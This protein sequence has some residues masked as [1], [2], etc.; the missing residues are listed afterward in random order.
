MST[1][2]SRESD[3]GLYPSSKR[4]SSSNLFDLGNLKETS[5]IQLPK[6]QKPKKLRSN[7]ALSS[8]MIKKHV[9]AD[10]VVKKKNDDNIR[11][12]FPTHDYEELLKHA[13]E[14]NSS[15]QTKQLKA[16]KPS[17]SIANSGPPVVSKPTS[18]NQPVCTSSP[19][20]VDQ[21]NNADEV[22][23]PPLHAP[24]DN[25]KISKK[26]PKI[27]SGKR[28]IDL[29]KLSS[30]S[31][32]SPPP[33]VLR[34]ASD[35]LSDDNRSVPDKPSCSSPDP[36]PDP[37][38]PVFVSPPETESQDATL[39]APEKTCVICP[40]C[41]KSMSSDFALAC[42]M[43]KRHKVRSKKVFIPGQSLESAHDSSSSNCSSKSTKE[44]KNVRGPPEGLE[45][46][47]DPAT[48]RSARNNPNASD[49]SSSSD[50]DLD[51]A[52]AFVY[53]AD[54][55]AQTCSDRSRFE[56]SIDDG[57]ADLPTASLI[58][59]TSPISHLQ[60]NKKEDDFDQDALTK[61]DE[62]DVALVPESS[63]P[64]RHPA[65]KALQPIESLEKI[66]ENVKSIESTQSNYVASE[67]SRNQAT[68][69]RCYSV[70][71][72]VIRN[73]RYACPVDDCQL[74][75][76]HYRNLKTHCFKKHWKEYQQIWPRFRRKKASTKSRLSYKKPLKIKTNLKNCKLSSPVSEGFEPVDQT[77]ISFD[78]QTD[79]NVA[80]D[81]NV[82]TR[83]PCAYTEPNQDS[84][85][86]IAK[87]AFS[88]Q[89]RSRRNVENDVTREPLSLATPPITNNA[90]DES[91]SKTRLVQ[92][93]ANDATENHSS[94]QTRP[95]EISDGN[96]DEAILT[97]EVSS[98]GSS[99]AIAHQK[100]EHRDQIGPSSSSAIQKSFFVTTYKNQK[101]CCPVENCTHN[102]KN[103]RHLKR[104]CKEKHSQF[105][106]DF[107]ILF[108]KT[109]EPI[110]W[111]KPQTPVKQV[112]KYFCPARDCFCVYSDFAVLQNHYTANHFKLKKK[113]PIKSKCARLVELSE[114]ENSD[115][116]ST[117]MT[118]TSKGVQAVGIEQLKKSSVPFIAKLRKGKH[119]YPI[120][121]CS[122]NYRRL[123]DREHSGKDKSVLSE[124]D[125]L[126]RD[127]DGATKD[128]AF[129]EAECRGDLISFGFV[130]L[131][132]FT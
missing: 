45:A 53:S 9:I 52:P 84:T 101:Y 91:S 51:D 40:I 79:Q 76:K 123:E 126:F 130:F 129:D 41:S 43:R 18:I 122:V 67:C 49:F 24:D 128:R 102:Y 81:N 29:R 44:S 47:S 121:G 5:S 35:S 57:R 94:A 62:D 65:D 59:S 22:T 46:C 32:Y 83:S 56:M 16:N 75:Y 10:V 74:S 112:I 69:E 107:A 98:A 87:P 80:A 7:R 55:S 23:F 48:F 27:V 1:L 127:D 71:E 28:R 14:L 13:E 100:K 19:D 110:H 26:A 97:N 96:I 66:S 30:L 108:M 114:T 77:D 42:H 78:A 50:D 6:K 68:S 4:S 36:D 88:L 38:E 25:D 86:D 105:Y 33:S 125:Q 106:L 131:R 8:S 120:Q 54:V 124:Q 92:V 113:K 93:S 99:S 111:C 12:L 11:Q 117:H 63:S 39:A 37:P 17:S 115:S 104:H 119:R 2:Q 3:E 85:N 70:A 90:N 61:A 21:S 34:N 132:C 109:S 116:P 31:K 95:N 73:N 60:N 89:T 58:F 64:V 103:F 72:I 15:G 82:I 118:E 20:P